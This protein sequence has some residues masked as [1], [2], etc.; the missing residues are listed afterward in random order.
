MRRTA[1]KSGR[2]PVTETAGRSSNVLLYL[3]RVIAAQLSEMCSDHAAIV[4]RNVVA[5][6]RA[7][8]WLDV[9]GSG[10]LSMLPF[11]TCGI[12][13]VGSAASWLWRPRGSPADKQPST[14]AARGHKLMTGHNRNFVMCCFRRFASTGLH[15]VNA[16]DLDGRIRD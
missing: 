1:L 4:Q 9:V 5:A 16:R 7:I 11:Q 12:F 2:P 15:P 14:R 13:R 8:W 3:L 10:L 6:T